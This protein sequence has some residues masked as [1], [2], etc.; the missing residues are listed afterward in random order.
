MMSRF[1]LVYFMMIAL[2]FKSDLMASARVEAIL[3]TPS[4]VPSAPTHDA[5]DVI[6]IF[7]DAYTDVTVDTYRTSWSVATLLDT[8]IADNAV[9]RYS[10]L[11]FVGIE[12]VA[13]QL[14]ITDMTHVH[15]DVWSGD[16]T[17]FSLKLVDFGP[18]GAFSNDEGKDDTEHQVDFMEPNKGEWI[19]Y[20]IPLSD[21]VNLSTKT[22]L[23]QYI[24]VGR[25]AGASTVFIDNFYFYKG[26]VVTPEEPVASAPTTAPSAPTHDAED[27]ISIFSDAYMDVTVD[28]YRTDWSAGTLLDTMIADNA[29]KRYSGLDFV[30]IET[31]AN[32]LDIT[33][34]THVHIDVWSSDFTQ[35]S[36]KL[37]DF[38]PDGAFSNAEDK[39][40]TEHQVDFMEPN[41]GEWI[42][43]D[44]PLS[45]FVNLTTKTKL[46]Q[47]ILVGRPA[48]A[49]TVFIDNFYFYK[50]EV[51][52]T[53][54]EPV[55]MAPSMAAP[56]PSH[57]AENVIS[58]FSDAYTD[59]TVDTYRTDWSA[60][61]LLDTMIADN[62][63][64]RY[65][66]LDFVGIETVANQLDIT[67]MTHVHIDVWSSDFTQFSMKLVDF[68]PDGAFSNAE[69]KDDTEHQVDFMEPNKGEWVSY[70]I[71]L[72]DFTN[73][74]TKTKLSQYILVGRPIGATTIFI[75]NFYF[76][77]NNPV[78]KSSD[79]TL[80]GI[81]IG[82]TPLAD[83][84]S[85][86]LQY[87]FILEEA[88]P[89]TPMVS[90]MATDANATVS[91]T[92]ATG[93]PGEA[94]IMVTAEDGITTKSYSISFTA[95]TLS[96]I[97]AST[98]V[99]TYPNPASNQLFVSLRALKPVSG[100]QAHAVNSI[101]QEVHLSYQLG[102]QGLV[103]D[104]SRLDQGLYTLR[105]VYGD[106]IYVAKFLK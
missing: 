64:K 80:S 103:L 13:N 56:A 21:F 88:N 74:T 32:Q 55:A 98:L 26:E 92:Q 34:M 66:G 60:G 29:V 83:F 45:D 1:T 79:A 68:G 62:A 12:T 70:D 50:G 100:I 5:E 16:F 75:D 33:E 102:S 30:G 19:S 2:L 67:D 47:Y 87:D 57:A 71:P 78:A 95:L 18:D 72:S 86:T 24:L 104:V 97:D 101:G 40:D 22:K 89:S 28:T 41:K 106:A 69:D 11:D 23:S 61:A 17:Q 46:S 39:D 25:P 9:K 15:I 48:G 99:S 84:A 76:Y 65:S 8:T 105:L 77:T 6:S 51:S 91:I 53:P 4:E 27:V 20:D 44:I 96:A 35:F 42:S 54:V 36:L 73:L 94:I 93:V 49:S 43:Y 3:S 59:V 85:E 38:G 14:D 58:L 81:S 37:V 31:V 82:E 52:I 7:S 90:A 10:G 63:V